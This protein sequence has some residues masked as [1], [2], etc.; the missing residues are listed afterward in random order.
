MLKLLMSKGV[1]AALPS[2]VATVTRTPSWLCQT[3][4]AVPLPIPPP[5]PSKFPS[6]D[7][8][9]VIPVERIRMRERKSGMNRLVSCF[10][11]SS[12]S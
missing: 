4:V 9:A 7:A 10:M 8:K 11:W 2:A 3:S 1:E 12:F 5:P 6:P